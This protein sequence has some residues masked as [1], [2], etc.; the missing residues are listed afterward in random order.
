MRPSPTGACVSSSTA[1]PKRKPMTAAAKKKSRKRSAHKQH[2]KNTYDLTTEQYEELLALQGGVCAICKEKRSYNLNVDHD[3]KTMRI[4]GL[5]CR[6]CNG[7][8]LTAARDRPHVLR[9]AADYLEAPPAEHVMPEA[10]VVPEPQLRPPR[11]RRHT[12][13]NRGG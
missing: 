3:H 1:S 6:L 10:H 4:R 12:G 9:A 13:P 7:R 8:L 5:L 11:R 2:I